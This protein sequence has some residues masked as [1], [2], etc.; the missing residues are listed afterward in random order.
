MYDMSGAVEIGTANCGSL[1]AK[2]SGD[3][4]F[5]VPY[6]DR[7]VIFTL[8]APDAPINLLSVGALNE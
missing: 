2:A 3:V 4:S 6:E 7:F 1:L 8:Q 5:H